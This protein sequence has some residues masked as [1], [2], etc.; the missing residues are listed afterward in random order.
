MPD[1]KTEDKAE[2]YS[3]GEVPTQTALVYLDSVT[4]ETLDINQAVLRI[5]NLITE[6]NK[7]I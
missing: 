6:M 7:R 2:R 4:K 5:L 1:K 3:L